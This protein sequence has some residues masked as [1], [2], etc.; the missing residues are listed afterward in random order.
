[1]NKID[2][3][4]SLLQALA[5][6]LIALFLLTFL[7]VPVLNVVY[8]A[9]ADGSGGLTLSHFGAFFGISLMQESFWNSLIVAFA[10]VFF[11][12]LIA[13][14]LGLLNESF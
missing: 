5:A 4:Y 2:R 11:A 3:Q 6:L 12:S 14:P 8:I 10:S 1:M 7:V 13:L 9:F